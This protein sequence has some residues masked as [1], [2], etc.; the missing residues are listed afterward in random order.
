M[1]RF[2]PQ[3]E[4]GNIRHHHV[5]QGSVLGNQGGLHG[6]A[7]GHHMIRIDAD[8]RQL[9][10]ALRGKG[11]RGRH[12]GRAADQN[13]PVDILGLHPGIRDRP[14]QRQRHALN[15]RGRDLLKAA[16]GQGQ[17]NLMRAQLRGNP[18]FGCC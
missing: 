16:A 18:H 1:G 15:Q 8:H 11:A 4:G 13:Q 12:P 17:V 3:S 14:V 7:Q 9:P 2:D 6:G 10:Q 5:I